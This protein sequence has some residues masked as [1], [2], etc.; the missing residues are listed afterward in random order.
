MTLT[1]MMIW[2]YFMWTMMKIVNSMWNLNDYYDASPSK[3]GQKLSP[4]LVLTYFETLYVANEIHVSDNDEC[5]NYNV[6]E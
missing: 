4:S 2:L 6:Y 1:T 3:K 5:Y